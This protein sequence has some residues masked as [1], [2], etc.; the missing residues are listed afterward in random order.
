[1]GASIG[2]RPHQLPAS[3]F[4]FLFPGECGV[5]LISANTGAF[6]RPDVIDKRMHR[7]DS[8]TATNTPDDGDF[9]KLIEEKLKQVVSMDLFATLQPP[10]NRQSGAVEEDANLEDV[11]PISDEELERQA[12]ADGGADN[13][14]STPE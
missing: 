4:A 6:H 5:I 12:L 14:P 2:H 9:S 3:F 13:D 8:M 10:V 7:G 1:V 11:P